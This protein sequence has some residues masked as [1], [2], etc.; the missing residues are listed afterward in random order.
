MNAPQPE[1]EIQRVDRALAEGEYGL[2]IDLSRKILRREPTDPVARRM[3]GGALVMAA[4]QDDPRD[5][6]MVDEGL[7]EIGKSLMFEPDH[8]ATL[9]VRGACLFDLGRLHEAYED[10]KHSVAL[11]P[12]FGPAH[13]GLVGVCLLLARYEEA[14]ASVDAHVERFGTPVTGVIWREIE[15]DGRRYDLGREGVALSMSRE[16]GLYT[17]DS[18]ELRIFGIGGTLEAAIDEWARLFHL[19]YID[20]VESG[21]ALSPEGQ[22]YAQRLRSTATVQ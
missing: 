7:G 3:L 10:L 6:A 20:F 8:P 12:T 5:D 9:Y 15:A 22:E 21:D 4:L 19:N 1:T 16:D 18:D 2:A 11:Q 14:Q 17:C 13:V